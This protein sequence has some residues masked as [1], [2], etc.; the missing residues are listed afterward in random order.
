L[1]EI[2]N[3]VKSYLEARRAF[4]AIAQKNPDELKGNDNI[5]GRI[6]EYLAISYLRS[7]SRRPKKVGSNSQKGHD[8][9]EGMAQISVKLLTSENIKGRGLRLTEPW[10]EL[11]LI[12][13]DTGSLEY[14]IGHISK[15][16]FEAARLENP[17]WSATPI[18]KK[19]MLGPKGLIGKYGKVLSRCFED[20]VQQAR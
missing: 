2:D 6:G 14:K 15:A 8:L 16:E 20:H 12:N 1:S 3:A 9:V 19:T 7:L 13:L 11:V 10:T 18:V 17:T 4:F 5:V